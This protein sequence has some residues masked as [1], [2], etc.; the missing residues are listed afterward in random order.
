MQVC[1]SVSSS[2]VAIVQNEMQEED[3]EC[4]DIKLDE[5]LKRQRSVLRKLILQHDNMRRMQ[6][7]SHLADN[8]KNGVE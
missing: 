8:I 6:K 4:Q 2:T 3:E 5:K 7:Y 1:Q